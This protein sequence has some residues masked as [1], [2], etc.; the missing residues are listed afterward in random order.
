MKSSFSF[1]YPYSLTLLA[2][3]LG[4]KGWHEAHKLL[5]IAK[6][7]TGIDIKTFDNPY[8]CAV[9]NGDFVQSHRY[10]NALKQILGKVHAGEDFEFNINSNNIK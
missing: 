9:M 8:H 10:S 7:K 2:P 1:G 5:A 3:A 6:D 4:F